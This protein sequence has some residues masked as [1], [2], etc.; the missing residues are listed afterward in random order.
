MQNLLILKY[1]DLEDQG[2][3]SRATIYRKVK[4]GAFPPPLDLGNGQPGWRPEDIQKW[5]DSRPRKESGDTSQ[6]RI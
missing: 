5:R 3:G 1:R 2:Y 6:E 4:K